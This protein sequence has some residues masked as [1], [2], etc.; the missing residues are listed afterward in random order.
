MG[1]GQDT[2]FS[3]TCGQLRGTI[4][5]LSPATAIRATCFCAD[6]RAAELWHGQPD[7]GAEGVDLAMLDP[8]RLR[9]DAG[10]ANLGV[11]RLSPKGILRWYATCCGARLFNTVQSPRFVF[12]TILSNRVAHPERLGPERARAFITR[13]DGKRGHRN[14][15]LLYLPMIGRSLARALTGGW[16]DNPLFD[17]ATGRPLADPRILT[18]AERRG[19]GLGTSAQDQR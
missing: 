1:A 2:A 7:P 9:L 16:R 12:V 17:R 18:R 3:C 10:A 5:D 8:A 19:L 4:R 11:I 13:P 14:A 6:C 15:H